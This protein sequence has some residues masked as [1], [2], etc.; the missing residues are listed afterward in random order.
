[1][2]YAYER[3]EENNKERGGQRRLT[4]TFDQP[5][6]PSFVIFIHDTLESG[7][8]N[9]WLASQDGRIMNINGRFKSR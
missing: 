6:K 5:H 7:V 3:S 4:R 2:N 1:M 8:Q 9:K